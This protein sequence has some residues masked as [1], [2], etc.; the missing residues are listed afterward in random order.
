MTTKKALSEK[1]KALFAHGGLP[2]EIDPIALDQVFTFWTTLTPRTIFKDIY[3]LPPGHFMIVKEG[4]IT[5]KAF[6]SLPVY[7]PED[8]WQGSFEE[9]REELSALLVDA[10]RLRLT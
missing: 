3:E 1:V 5:Q 8:R 10:T 9:A 7:S 4:E 6:W 2:A